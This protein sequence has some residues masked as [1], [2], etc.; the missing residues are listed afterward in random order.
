MKSNTL[1]LHFY[2]SSD[3]IRN[4][5]DE[6]SPLFVEMASN[7]RIELST[8][9]NCEIISLGSI[10]E[11]VSKKLYQ[12]KLKL[13]FNSIHV[14]GTGLIGSKDIKRKIITNNFNVHAV[15]GIKTQ[16]KIGARTTVF[17]DPG[18]LAKHLIP[19]Q[20]KKIKIL[21][22]PHIS[23]R[24]LVEITELHNKIK[25][26]VIADLSQDPIDIL[27][28]ISSADLVLSSSL[29]GLICADS[30]GVPN[31]RLDVGPALKGGDFK[32]DDYYSSIK[33]TE[34]CVT[35]NESE[36][37][38]LAQFENIDPSYR[39]NIDNLCDTLLDSFP[40]ELK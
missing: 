27:K 15:R 8:V 6:L 39:E 2:R 20:R 36:K 16:E 4:F 3:G 12:R 26:S 23:H 38:L 30:F 31:I 19:T 32:F 5:G 33:R 28:L 40:N 37:N 18:L 29:H 13:N 7:R 24:N 14:W 21:I 1:K 22:M 11:G 34:T 10:L 35:V 25:G 9:A 17:G